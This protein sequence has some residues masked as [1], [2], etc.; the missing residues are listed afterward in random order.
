MVII[1]DLKHEPKLRKVLDAYGY[2]LRTPP[3]PHARLEASG[4]GIRVTLYESGKLLLQGKREAEV[5]A[6]LAAFGLFGEAAKGKAEDASRGDAEGAEEDAAQPK[7]AKSKAAARSS[8]GPEDGVLEAWIGSDET[9]KG[10]YFGPLVV[11]A[12]HVPPGLRAELRALGVR[13]S[14]TIADGPV[15]R[16]AAEVRRRCTVEVIAINPRRYNE[17]YA[18]FK[19]VNKLLAWAHGK[20]IEAVMERHP[21]CG[22]ILT[23]QFATDPNLMR[24]ALGPL[25]R[26]ARYD[27][28]PRAEEE[29]AVAAASIVA[30]AVFLEKLTELSDRAGMVLLKGASAKVEEA[31]VAYV[32]KHGR[33][34]LGEVAKLHFQTTDRVLAGSR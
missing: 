8:A 21:D 9:G 16:L 5:H 28:R 23:D 24:R 32:A 19:N 34:K 27:Q 2:G 14:K 29:V 26:N 6:E 7:G 17:M 18:D 1:F 31:A 3:P 15:Q 10:D 11:A 4:E 30:R 25:S 20:A 22:R 13:D 12:V 33:E